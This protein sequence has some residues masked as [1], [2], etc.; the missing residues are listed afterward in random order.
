MKII[1]NKFFLLNS[2]DSFIFINFSIFNLCILN[3]THYNSFDI[4]KG[5]EITLFGFSIN[6]NYY[7]YKEK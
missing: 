7:N 2:K 5:I 6:L 4:Y 1:F 3:I